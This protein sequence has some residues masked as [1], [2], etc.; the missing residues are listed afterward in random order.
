[1]SIDDLDEPDC[2][3]GCGA[4]MDFEQCVF[5]GGDGTYDRH[6]EDPIAFAPGDTAPCDQCDGR[7]GW[8]FC[9]GL[10]GKAAA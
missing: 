2:C 1:M 10:C 4:E 5:C 7:G 6:E 8:V 3:D 9:S